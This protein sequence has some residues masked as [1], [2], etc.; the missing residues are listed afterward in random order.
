MTKQQVIDYV[1]SLIERR[2]DIALDRKENYPSDSEYYKWYIDALYDI[3]DWLR[4]KLE[5]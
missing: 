5:K 3:K 1:N 4:R 2:N